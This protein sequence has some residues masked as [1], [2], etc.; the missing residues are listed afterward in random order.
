MQST[1][2][3]TTMDGIQHVAHVLHIKCLLAT[4]MQRKLRSEIESGGEYTLPE[5]KLSQICT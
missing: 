5:T 3:W 2:I 4:T 1:I